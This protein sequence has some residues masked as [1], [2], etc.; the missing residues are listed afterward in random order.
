MTLHGSFTWSMWLSQTCPSAQLPSAEDWRAMFMPHSQASD[1]DGKLLSS[2]AGLE[3]LDTWSKKVHPDPVAKRRSLPPGGRRQCCSRRRR[4]WTTIWP[5]SKWRTAPV[6]GLSSPFPGP[7]A[8]H[9]GAR[10][11]VV[12]SVCVGCRG[13]RRGAPLVYR[14]PTKDAGCL[15]GAHMFAGLTVYE[16]FSIKPPPYQTV[17][18]ARSGGLEQAV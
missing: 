11:T 3:F 14:F 13:P 4:Q 18:Q 7:R 10:L 6:S 2:K 1:A 12:A 9:L 5:R 8:L 15:P 16:M 17:A